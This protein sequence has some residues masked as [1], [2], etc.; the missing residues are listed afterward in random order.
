[1]QHDPSGEQKGELESANDRQS[2]FM[3]QGPQVLYARTRIK[4]P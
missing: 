1:V 2:A 3:P 4:A